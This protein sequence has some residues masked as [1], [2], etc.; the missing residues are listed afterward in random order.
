M[1][2]LLIDQITDWQE[3][4]RITGI[5]NI[6]MSEDFLEYHFRSQPIMPG[7]LLLEA[8][9]QL[10]GWLEAV[11]SDFTHWISI[12][13][14]RKC[15][16]YGFALPGDQVELAVE[17]LSAEEAGTKLYRGSGK[18]KGKKKIAVEFGG[19]IGPLSELEDPQEQRKFF[20]ILNRETQL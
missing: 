16:F 4:R 13:K 8:L 6:A 15:S 10:A 7:V 9:T 17:F 18:V 19:K 14:V 2:Y 5:K 20:Q 3:G 1:R 11:S 12:N